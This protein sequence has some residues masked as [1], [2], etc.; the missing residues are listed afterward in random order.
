MKETYFPANLVL[1]SLIFDIDVLMIKF[2]KA[3]KIRCSGFLFRI[4]R[5]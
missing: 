4:V 1:G 2:G 5:F 3:E